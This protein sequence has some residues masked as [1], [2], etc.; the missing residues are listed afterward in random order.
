MY[1]YNVITVLRECQI[2]NSMPP[3]KRSD[4]RSKLLIERVEDMRHWG[5]WGAAPPQIF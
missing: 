4:I 5:L 2:V 1:S 3:D